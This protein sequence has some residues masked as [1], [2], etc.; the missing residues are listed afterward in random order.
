MV[1]EIR[2]HLTEHVAVARAQWY[3]ICFHSHFKI[4]YDVYVYRVYEYHVCDK[5]VVWGWIEQGEEPT[6]AK[7]LSHVG[8]NVSF[9][10]LR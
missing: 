3:L 2:K 10:P 7:T 8:L 9:M 1:W 5:P 6:Q 4:Y